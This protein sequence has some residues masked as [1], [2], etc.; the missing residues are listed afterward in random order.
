MT[1]RYLIRSGKAEIMVIGIRL[2]HLIAAHRS[3]TLGPTEIIDEHGEVL[4]VYVDGKK[5]S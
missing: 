1:S 2:A 5:I 4:A 3:K